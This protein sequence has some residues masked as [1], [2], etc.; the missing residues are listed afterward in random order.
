MG[1]TDSSSIAPSCFLLLD[2]NILTGFYAPETLSK[3]AAGAGPRIRTIIDSVRKGCTT[4]LRLL[5]PE[6]CVA[7]AQTVLSKHAN[8]KWKIM[9]TGEHRE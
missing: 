4:D 1:A 6:I 5:V 7:E 3:H 8:P 2:A 9:Q